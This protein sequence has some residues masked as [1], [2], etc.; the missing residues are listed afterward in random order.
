MRRWRGWSGDQEASLRNAWL[1]GE[2]ISEIAIKVGRNKHAVVVKA[3]RMELPQY[4]PAQ[5]EPEPVPFEEL[6]LIPLPKLQRRVLAALLAE[7]PFGVT[8]KRLGQIIFTDRY[9]LA[10]KENAEGVVRRLRTSLRQ[11]GWVAGTTGD[12]TGVKLFPRRDL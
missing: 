3:H 8:C 4:V 1:A 10:Q 12:R 7:H 5:G 11:Y 6:D 9:V 2:P